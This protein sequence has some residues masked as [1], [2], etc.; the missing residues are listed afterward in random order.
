MDIKVNSA[1]CFGAKMITTGFGTRSADAKRWA[2]IANL[3]E[4][5][6]V[7]HPADTFTISRK[8]A[9]SNA[10][11]P[12]IYNIDGNKYE[13]FLLENK[14]F[15]Y[16]DFMKLSDE[17]IAKKFAK[18]ME[19]QRQG[20]ELVA[21][22]KEKIKGLADLFNVSDIKEGLMCNVFR[23][24]KSAS[25]AQIKTQKDKDDVLKHFVYDVK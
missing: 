7:M 16:K 3:F 11:L 4:K 5:E 19:L 23:E 8:C 21:K 25:R 10:G 24:V 15:A 22:S 14:N 2:N 12:F 20:N 1:N 18:M 17:A 9:Y 13:G 6:T